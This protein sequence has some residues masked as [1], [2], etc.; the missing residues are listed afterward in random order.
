MSRE[1]KADNAFSVIFGEKK[2]GNL[3]EISEL[4]QIPSLT[5]FSARI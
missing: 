1:R 4:K 3:P 2:N 5:S